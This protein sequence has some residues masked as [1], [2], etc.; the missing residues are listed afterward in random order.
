MS[1]LEP[2]WEKI[3]TGTYKGRVKFRY[4]EYSDPD[5]ERVA[6]YL[7]DKTEC[8]ALKKEIIKILNDLGIE[9][10][11]DENAKEDI[12]RLKE[13]RL[14]I[15]TVVNYLCL[16]SAYECYAIIETGKDHRQKDIKK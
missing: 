10:G 5:N 1:L 14:I 16:Y 7:A 2:I 11:N 3:K 6:F 9:S 12:I 13:K 4:G 8:K 15:L